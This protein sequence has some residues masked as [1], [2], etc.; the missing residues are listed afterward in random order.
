MRAPSTAST[1]GSR[2]VAD[3]AAVERM[4]EGHRRIASF[5]QVE[6]DL[7]SSGRSHPPEQPEHHHKH[8]KSQGSERRAQRATCQIAQHHDAARR[9]KPCR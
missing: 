8:G 3:D 1:P 6:L 7:Q 2:E 4:R 5:H 9:Q